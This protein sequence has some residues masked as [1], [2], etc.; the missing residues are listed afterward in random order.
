MAKSVILNICAILTGRYYILD[1]KCSNQVIYMLH[2]SG[3]SRTFR[4]I[5][6]LEIA[7]I[8]DVFTDT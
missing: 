5:H 3:G 1:T 6:H 7:H 4:K 8:L 2:G